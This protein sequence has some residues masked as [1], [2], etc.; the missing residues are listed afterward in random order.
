MLGR[1]ALKLSFFIVATC[2]VILAFAIVGE[3][4]L[5]WLKPSGGSRLTL[6]ILADTGVQKPVPRPADL[7]RPAPVAATRPA[8][9]AA[10]APGPFDTVG[11]QAAPTA[12]PVPALSYAEPPPASASLPAAPQSPPAS[13]SASDADP[14][15]QGDIPG[16]G[17]H[18]ASL[19]PPST[20]DQPPAAVAPQGTPQVEDQPISVADQSA[21][22]RHASFKGAM[23]DPVGPNQAGQ[24]L[25][26]LQIGDL[27]TAADMF[28]G[29]VRQRLQTLYGDGGAGYLVVGKPHPG[30]RSDI[31]K[32]AASAGWAYKAIQ[33][34][35]DFLR[36][37]SVGLQRPVVEGRRDADAHDRFA[38][39][40]RFHRHRGEARARFGGCRAALRQ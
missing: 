40:L 34:A 28:T 10:A 29:E 23:S 18:V 9:A 16:V 7:A 31:L 6:Q 3:M 24:S 25:R 20:T 22:A 19:E 36:L 1:N 30:V 11:P 13:P 14:S 5:H 39:Q 2:T 15:G 21:G 33:R 26:I 35:D 32:M 38:D 4:T 12:S 27:H 8:P 37:P 17:Q